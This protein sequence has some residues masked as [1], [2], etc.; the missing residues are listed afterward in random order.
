MEI[1]KTRNVSLAGARQNIQRVWRC[2]LHQLLLGVI[3]PA[4]FIDIGLVTIDP[5]RV[6]LRDCPQRLIRPVECGLR[7]FVTFLF[8]AIQEV[9]CIGTQPRRSIT[10]SRSPKTESAIVTLSIEDTRDRSLHTVPGDRLIVASAFLNQLL[11]I[12]QRHRAADRLFGTSIWIACQ[13]IVE[14]ARIDR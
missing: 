2:P 7:H 12:D 3:V 8:N 13:G 4:A 6:A 10:V 1:T 9:T 5:P 11:G 14:C